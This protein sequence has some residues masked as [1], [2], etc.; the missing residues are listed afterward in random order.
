[1]TQD[2]TRITNPVAPSASIGTIPKDVK[3]FSQ[4]D[5]SGSVCEEFYYIG[6]S[7]KVVEPKM[8]QFDITMHP[9]PCAA[10]WNTRLSTIVK[11]G[12]VYNLYIQG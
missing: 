6:D 2:Y 12:G 8:L 4:I 5:R 3:V 7:T 9:G 10:M 1:M 11:N